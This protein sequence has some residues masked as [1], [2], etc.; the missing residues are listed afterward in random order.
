[1]ATDTANVIAGMRRTGEVCML[2]AVGV[3]AKA[4][5]VRIR[6][7]QVF[8]NDDLA[9]VASA[10]HVCL[11]RTVASLAIHPFASG[12]GLKSHLVVGRSFHRLVD[13]LMAPLTG[14]R[15]HVLPRIL[16]L[17]CGLRSG[18][19]HVSRLHRTSSY[20]QEGEKQERQLADSEMHA[21]LRRTWIRIARGALEPMT[22]LA[23]QSRLL[24]GRNSPVALPGLRQLQPG[25]EFPFRESVWHTP[26]PQSV[27]A[28]T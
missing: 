7:A 14:F 9:F 26:A 20:E 8:E 17:A 6:H 2:V 13:V 22:G 27:T 28:V 10:F 18:L 19:L 23:G 25:T 3:T 11:S 4:T 5:L 21:S 24:A 16:G 1:M 12:A 15:T